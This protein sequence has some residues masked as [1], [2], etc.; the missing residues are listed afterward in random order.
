MVLNIFTLLR[1]PSP[2]SE[3]RMFS[4]H[5]TETPHPC[6]DRFL[7]PSSPG[8]H[9]STVCESEL[10]YSRCASAVVGFPQHSVFELNLCSPAFETILWAHL[11][12]RVLQFFTE[13]ASLSA[14]FHMWMKMKEKIRVFKEEAQYLPT[15]SSESINTPRLGLAYR[16]LDTVLA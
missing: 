8:S 6:T 4:P 12:T 5:K 15:Y 11:L 14:S 10:S 3:L 7:P 16:S 13:M 9:C 2:L 1:L